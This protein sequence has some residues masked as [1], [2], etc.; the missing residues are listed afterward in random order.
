V[1]PRNRRPSNRTANEDAGASAPVR[2]SSR[3]A[4]DGRSGSQRSAPEEKSGKRRGPAGSRSG[5]MSQ[6]QMIGLCAGAV[7][8]LSIGGYLLLGGSKDGGAGKNKGVEVKDEGE[9]TP[10]PQLVK[11]AEQ[12]EASGNRS[13][14]VKYYTR[15]ANRAEQDGN[16]DAAVK[17]NM[18]AM[19]LIKTSKLHD[20]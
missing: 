17:Y 8:V 12:C 6:G 7:A 19:N 2:P 3:R 5:G 13:A 11:L 16:S 20:R 9:K 18:K 14:A 15:A 4:A 10:C 1:V